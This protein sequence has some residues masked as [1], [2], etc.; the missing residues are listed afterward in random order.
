MIAGTSQR[1]S[2]VSTTTAVRSS[3]GNRSS[4]SSGQATTSSPALGIRSRV[5]NRDRASET[6]VRQP[7]TFAA[8]QS[9]SARSTAP[10]TRS[11]GGG[12]STSAKTCSPSISCSPVRVTS[13]FVES[14]RSPAR[15]PSTTV[16]A[17]CAASGS[18]S[19]SSTRSTK[20]SISPPH[21]SPTS[22][23][24]SSAIPYET[25]LGRPL[26]KTSV[27][28]VATSLS[29]HPPDTD[30]ASSPL[31]ET[32]IFDP[33]GRGADRRVATTVASATAFPSARHRFT[34]SRAS[35]TRLSLPTPVSLLEHRGAG[36]APPNRVVIALDH[37][38]HLPVPTLQRSAL[39]ED[40]QPRPPR[41]RKRS[42]ERGLRSGDRVQRARP[43][44]PRR[45]LAIGQEIEV[46]ARDEGIHAVVRRRVRADITCDPLIVLVPERVLD[47][48]VAARIRRL[49]ER[50][51]ERERRQRDDRRRRPT[52][53]GNADSRE[54]DGNEEAQRREQLDVVVGPVGTAEVDAHEGASEPD[55]R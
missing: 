22:H 10:K 21:G 18:G 2:C 45:R 3:G 6:I 16:N 44:E 15:S 40:D 36:R 54:R 30:P 47:H 46:G 13:P 49:H 35:R 26:A 23:A 42:R 41:R 48:A 33:S 7:S 19:S 32:A 51:Q 17:T 43:D 14:Q 24:S 53:R 50:A 34:A 55:K 12:P 37:G 8:R 27:A 25:S 39:E 5:A 1:S 20:T 29:T 28:W 11:S 4:A 31:S 52:E 38:V 9:S